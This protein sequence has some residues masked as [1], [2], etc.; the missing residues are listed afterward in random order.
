MSFIIDY[1]DAWDKNQSK[2]IHE[3]KTGI[4]M[5]YSLWVPVNAFQPMLFPFIVLILSHLFPVCEMEMQHIN[6]EELEEK[7]RV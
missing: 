5:E 2:K 7:D 1:L 6:L 3:M 4:V